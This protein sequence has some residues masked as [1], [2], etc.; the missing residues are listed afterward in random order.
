MFENL[1]RSLRDLLDSAPAQGGA[2][3]AQM[4]ETLV[5]AR[6]GIGEMRQGVEETQLALTAKERELET[7][8]RRRGQAQAIGDAETVRVAERYEAELASRVEVLARKLAAQRDELALGEHEVREMTAELRKAIGGGA[9]PRPVASTDPLADESTAALDEL[10]ALERA[11]GRAARDADADA[12][13]AEL[14]RKMGK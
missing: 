3:L 14:K 11:R 1:R 12:R 13:L 2:S 5:Q 4:R 8:R 9:V 7:V 10:A 6:V